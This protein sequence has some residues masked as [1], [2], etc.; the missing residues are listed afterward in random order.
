MPIFFLY[1]QGE[2][3]QQI[4]LVLLLCLRQCCSHP[5]LIGTMLAKTDFEWIWAEKGM[6][7][8]ANSILEMS[9]EN[10]KGVFSKIFGP[11]NPVFDQSYVSSKLHYK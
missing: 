11:E 8:N 10:P 9:K 1:E 7:K 4:V 2:N 6:A 5:A 3:P